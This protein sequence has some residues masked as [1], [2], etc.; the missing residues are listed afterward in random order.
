MLWDILTLTFVFN[1]LSWFGMNFQKITPM[2]NLWLAPVTTLLSSDSVTIWVQFK[3]SFWHSQQTWLHQFQHVYTA[4]FLS[5]LFS[6][7]L[8]VHT[9]HIGQ[10]IHHQCILGQSEQ[11]CYI[12]NTGYHWRFSRCTP[13]TQTWLLRNSW[14]NPI[15]YQPIQAFWEKNENLLGGSGCCTIRFCDFSA[16]FPVPI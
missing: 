1:F 3:R 9:N 10:L 4:D 5:Q 12:A 15:T 6:R 8:H 14:A 16:R 11:L 2:E 13:Y 7:H